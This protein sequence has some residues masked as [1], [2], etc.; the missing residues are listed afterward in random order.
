[1]VSKTALVVAPLLAVL[2]ALLPVPSALPQE[3]GRNAEPPRRLLLFFETE[4]GAQLSASERMLL[5]ESLL[6]K[7]GRASERIAV[8]EYE[9]PEAPGSDE[10]R[11][12]AAE[13]RRADS[14]VL[15][16]VGGR[17]PQLTVVSRAYDLVRAEPAFDLSFEA[18][19]RRGAV[20]LERHFWDPVTEAAAGTLSGTGKAVARTVSREQMTIKAVPGTRIKGLDE[21]PV[22]IGDNG[23]TTLE[24]LLPATFSLRA[25]KLGYDPID[26]DYYVEPGI[27][28]LDLAQ[29]RGSRW[30]FSFYLQ[31][32]NYPGFDASFYPVPDFYWVKLGFNTFL[33]GLVLAEEREQSMLVS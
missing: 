18:T 8:L 9:N 16:T 21:E 13:S 17:W 31:M 2:L 4:G 24:A 15:V 6:I 11:N 19:V 10:L 26:R 22:E 32:M 27:G 1:M 20:E 3:S 28:V 23:E 5:Y 7:L 14:W 29:E 33:V 25:T 30:A 12:T